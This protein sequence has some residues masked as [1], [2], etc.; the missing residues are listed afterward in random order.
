MNARLAESEV[1]APRRFSGQW[2]LSALRTL[3]WVAVITALI[4]V[5][6]DLDRTETKQVNAKLV[7]HADSTRNAMVVLGPKQI[8]VAFQVK[9]SSYAISQ[10]AKRSELK[11]DAAKDLGEGVHPDVS[12]KELLGRLDELRAAPFEI[13]G[14][15]KPPS[16]TIHLERTKAFLNLP[17]E[18]DYPAGEPEGDPVIEPAKVDLYVP[19]SQVTPDLRDP[20]PLRIGAN[21][22][23]PGPGNGM[24]RASAC[25][26]TIFDQLGQV[27]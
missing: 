6:A 21:L 23:L 2:F 16:I 8:A 5:Y 26:W 11:Y 20:G 13:I 22:R 18:P 3:G 15:P 12:V 17:V 1:P 24:G 9:G 10:L 7:I 14:L 25:G 4:W 19:V 27:L